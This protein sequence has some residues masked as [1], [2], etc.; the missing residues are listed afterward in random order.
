MERRR[1]YGDF[2]ASIL[3]L[4]G[5]GLG[6]VW[7]Q[8]SRVEAVATVRRAVELGI[9]LIDLAPRYGHGESERVLGEAFD[10]SL[11]PGVRVETKCLLGSPPP[12]EVYDRLSRSLDQS[13]ELMRLP[14]VDL[15]VLH[16]N[17][18]FDAPP[19]ATTRTN[20][21]LFRTAVIPAFQRLI[22]EGRI[23]AWGVTGIGVPD[24]L[25]DVLE[26]EPKPA[27]IQCIANPLHSAGGLQRF[28]G[29]LRAGDIIE[30]AVRNGVGVLGIR[31]VQAGALVDVPDRE[32]PPAEAADFER[33]A[34][35]RAL[36]REL[37]TTSAALA[38]RYAVSLPGIASVVLGVKNRDELEECVAAAEAGPLTP[39]EMDRIDRLFGRLPG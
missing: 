17:I 2:D 35:F 4:G 27:L 23:G 5:G 10:G 8:T 33:A 37:G 11:P 38:H 28:E 13:L 31:A 9:N 6:Q 16:D 26:S 14:R 19:G 34:P 32:L 15:L 20:R 36:A 21:D 3:T 12:E 7:G 25:I 39:E 1:L 30:T 29:E 24:A 18:S 22:E